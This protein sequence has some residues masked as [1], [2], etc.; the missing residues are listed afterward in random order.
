MWVCLAACSAYVGI[1]VYASP[2]FYL[3]ISSSYLVAA[4]KS[5]LIYAL[6]RERMGRQAALCNDTEKTLQAG[7]R[8]VVCVKQEEARCR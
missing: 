2:S 4:S 6:K 3:I 8:F 7:K 1:N 5:R